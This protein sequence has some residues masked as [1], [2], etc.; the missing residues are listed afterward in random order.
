MEDRERMAA[1]AVAIYEELFETFKGRLSS[2]PKW[3]ES[4]MHALMDAT[5]DEVRGLDLPG[6]STSDEV[7]R[8]RGRG[9]PELCSLRMRTDPGR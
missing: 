5:F 7:A 6:V 1:E 3:T 2:D 8:H 9:L 4:R